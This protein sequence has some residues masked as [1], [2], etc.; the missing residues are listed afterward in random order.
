MV[1]GSG[2]I[3][4]YS[5]AAEF[6]AGYNMYNY[7]G[8]AYYYYPGTLANFPSSSLSMLTFR[9]T[10]GDNEWSVGGDGAGGGDGG[11]K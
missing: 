8:R 9:G 5:I 2:T 7:L 3:D 6:G 10:S 11:G 1:L 4:M